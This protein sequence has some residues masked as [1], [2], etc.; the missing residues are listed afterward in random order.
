MPNDKASIVDPDGLR[1]TIDEAFEKYVGRVKG[2]F[3]ECLKGTV[4]SDHI[5]SE[6]QKATAAF[7]AT[8]A[9]LQALHGEA[10]FLSA[11]ES[12]MRSIPG[13]KVNRHPSHEGEGEQS[14]AG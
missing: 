13:A 6:Y 12:S 11:L 7:I 5:R 14:F 3:Y 10:A 2:S 9:V 8:C 4:G 1:Q